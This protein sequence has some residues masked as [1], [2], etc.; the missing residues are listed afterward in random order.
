[1]NKILKYILSAILFF[2]IV[3]I[4]VSFVVQ[5]NVIPKEVY[6]ISK[7]NLVNDGSF[8]DFNE[9]AGDC[10]N[11]NPEKSKVFAFK[12]SDSFQGSYSLNL[13][14]ENQCAC[15][16]KKLDY[17][18]KSEKFLLEFLFRGDNRR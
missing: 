14:S 8:E 7:E 15:Y 1:M 4:V 6:K 12:S 2:L 13:K 11:S 17:S 9:T 3:I 10:C 5:Y 16:S 18:N